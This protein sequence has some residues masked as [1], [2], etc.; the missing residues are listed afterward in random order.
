MSILIID[1]YAQ[2][3][4]EAR[5][6]LEQILS[7]SEVQEFADPRAA[8]RYFQDHQEVD[9]ILT[10]IVMPEING[11]EVARAVLEQRIIPVILHT[12]SWSKDFLYNLGLAGA[13]QK[14]PVEV[15]T[16]QY[17]FSSA[18]EY[19]AELRTHIE[20]AQQK[21]ARIT[22]IDLTL[23]DRINQKVKGRNDNLI[24]YV[25]SVYKELA[26]KLREAASSLPGDI[27]TAL[28][29]QG[30]NFSQ[31]S[32]DNFMHNLS[33]P[34]GNWGMVLFQHQEA[35]W[36]QAVHSIIAK[37]K[38]VADLINSHQERYRVSAGS[39]N[40]YKRF[41][42]ARA[43][44]DMHSHDP[45][46]KLQSRRVLLQ[47]TGIPLVV[48]SPEE[49]PAKHRDEIQRVAAH[50][51]KIIA[52]SMHTAED[53]A[54]PLAGYFDSVVSDPERIAEAV[55]KVRASTEKTQLQELCLYRGFT[56]PTRAGMFIGIEPYYATKYLGAALEHP[57]HENLLLIEFGLRDDSSV[58]PAR[59]WILYDAAQRR[60]LQQQT[61]EDVEASE[62]AFA[63]ARRYIHNRSKLAVAGMDVTPF[64]FQ[65]EAGFDPSTPYSL[66]DFQMRQFQRKKPA[67]DLRIESPL[68]A[69][70]VMG[71]TSGMDVVVCKTQDPDVLGMVSQRAKEDGLQVCYL[72]SLEKG[73]NTNLASYS[74]NL[75]LLITGR[76]LAVQEHGAFNAMMH[77]EQIV[78]LDPTE[79]SKLQLES[80]DILRYRS[81]GT[82]GSF[83]KLDQTGGLKYKIREVLN[84]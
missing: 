64:S 35:L 7:T 33:Y 20:N 74:D 36:Y 53:G 55:E 34:L 46:L 11:I 5:A 26:G 42:Q 52:R 15:A 69:Q 1:D 39:A 32:T 43:R 4:A 84:K 76:S 57:H 44:T 49:D 68:P 78:L 14:L 70:L 81:N 21:A 65:M 48:L 29:D 59:H 6:A 66:H 22:S 45:P 67:E 63:F 25:K 79:F 24:G 50:T 2:P 17:F 71:V 51:G 80:G 75:G 60:I 73:T 38:E 40:A 41:V 47:D 28:L 72:A 77:A 19:Q 27:R 58:N 61:P 18:A 83:T 10:D 54:I 12:G 37:M 30:I 9:L 82:Q 3:R 8:V 13:E 16:K 23:L 56:P 62:I 31:E